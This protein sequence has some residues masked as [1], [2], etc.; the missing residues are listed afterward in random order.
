MILHTFIGL[1]YILDG[2]VI[3]KLPGLV[4]VYAA[5]YT[6]TLL[7][8]ALGVSSVI[9]FGSLKRR[10]SGSFAPVA[11]VALSY[12]RKICRST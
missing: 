6:S 8:S 11:L 3:I 5:M 2:D 12:K 9:Q 4:G 7:L 10:T 1:R